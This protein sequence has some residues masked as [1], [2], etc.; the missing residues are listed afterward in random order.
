MT[1]Q[2]LQ[3]NINNPVAPKALASTVASPNF[4]LNSDDGF[5]AVD[6]T[7]SISTVTL[8]LANSMPGRAIVIVNAAAVPLALTVAA[9][10]GDTLVAPAGAVNPIVGAQGS[11]TVVSDGGT[12]WY[13][14]NSQ[15]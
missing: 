10:A 2:Y 9:A 15:A 8:P 12:N 1:E 3:T 4:T 13:V 11:L 5:V 6:T 7:L 14:S